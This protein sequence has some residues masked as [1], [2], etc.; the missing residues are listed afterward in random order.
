MFF[1]FA[2]VIYFYILYNTNDDNDD[3]GVCSR[4][5]IYCYIILVI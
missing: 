3:D 1:V 5:T 4:F 2:S